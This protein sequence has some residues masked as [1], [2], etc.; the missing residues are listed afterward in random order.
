[1]QGV[2]E[3]MFDPEGIKDPL[4]AF[5][6]ELNKT[7][8]DQFLEAF[9]AHSAVMPVAEQ[10][11]K[12]LTKFLADGMID[13]WEAV[14]LD[15]WRRRLMQAFQLSTQ[16]LEEA[17][18]YL[19]FDEIAEEA[20][21][22]LVQGVK[23]GAKKEIEAFQTVSNITRFQANQIIAQ[24]MQHSNYLRGIEANTAQIAENTRRGM[25]GQTVIVNKADINE[26]SKELANRKINEERAHGL[27]M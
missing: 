25:I 13:Q 7:I 22:E 12:L 26:I 1:M 21:R 17:K 3:A 5:V 8:L 6:N 18:K 2:W 19:P 16:Q 15:R 27:I 24:L 9:A 10:Y 20:G 4:A 11:G 23:E 14:E